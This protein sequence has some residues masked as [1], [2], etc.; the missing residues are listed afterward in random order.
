[1]AIRLLWAL[2]ALLLLGFV[3]FEA[4]EHGWVMAGTVI[5]FVLLPDVTLVGAFD[6]HRRGALLPRRVTFYNAAHR[7]WAAL[8]LV[9][10]G[11]LAPM[12][13]VAGVDGGGKLVAV[14]GIAWLL[15]IASDRAVGYG[16]RDADGVIRSVGG[17]RTPMT[18]WA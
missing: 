2:V 17:T 15:H 5:A 7:P 14:A 9:V 1:M 18:C 16:L 10:V 3:I 8:V 11:A 13:G 12:P 4:I 6:P